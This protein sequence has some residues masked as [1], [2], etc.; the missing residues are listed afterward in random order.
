MQFCFV[1]E[2]RYIIRVTAVRGH[3]PLA[4]QSHQEIDGLL[5]FALCIRRL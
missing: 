5:V 4:G 2:E 1:S 3:T